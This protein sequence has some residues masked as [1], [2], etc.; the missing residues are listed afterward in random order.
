M[1][2]IFEAM[3]TEVHVTA[4]YDEEATAGL[5]AGTFA[6]AERRFSRF[7]EES[8]LYALNRAR[9][10]FEASDELFEMLRRARDY[11]EMTDGLFDPGVGATLCALGYDRSFAH[12]ALDR[13][14]AAKTPPAGRFLDVVLDDETRTVWRPP[15]VQIDL[16]GMAKGSTVDLAARHLRGS[17]AIDAGGDAIVRGPA[18]ATET[19]LIE[20]EDP[21]DRSRTI[22]S[23]A[24]RDVAVATS[25]T[26]RRN[27]RVGNTF[28]HHL[29]DPRTQTSSTS[30]LLQATVITP[31]AELADVLAKAA[32]L[33]G[34]EPARRFL[35]P[36]SDVGAVL[37]ARSGKIHFVGAV[38]VR[39]VAHA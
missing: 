2:F 11:V 27:W 33:L 26:N 12:G 6:R 15:H 39:E 19:W 16:G 20:I 18:P 17:G 34:A 10:P 25:A 29:I 3:N 37:V 22:A 35:E 21:V 36:R 31:R 13:E 28:A 32:L 4:S 8:E 24:A 38:D 5:V 7:R 23:V 30:D 1:M 14:R 9:G